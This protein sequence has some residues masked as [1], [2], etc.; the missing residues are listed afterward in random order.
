MLFRSGK[1]VYSVS[2]PFDWNAYDEIRNAKLN[3]KL[4]K[5]TF[6]IINFLRSNQDTLILQKPIVEVGEVVHKGDILTDGAATDKGELALGR[7]VTVA[8]MTW[9]GYNYEDAIV[10]SE[11]LV[12]Q[13]VYTSIHIDELQVES[14]ET[15]L[16][17]EMI[18]REVPGANRDH[19][20]YLDDRGII[21]PL[22]S[23][24]FK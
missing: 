5:T 18:T 22:S 23:K 3:N 9:E 21:I 8:F 10:M 16:G 1:V 17:K 13:D 7:N 2:E 6:E 4:E 15:K 19:L 20:K 24:Y 11:E 12:K 14:R